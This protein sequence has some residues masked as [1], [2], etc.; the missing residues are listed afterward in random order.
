MVERERVWARDLIPLVEPFGD[1][2]AA[3]F[4]PLTPMHPDEQSTVALCLPLDDD[5][6]N[7]ARVCHA[8]RMSRLDRLFRQFEPTMPKGKGGNRR[9]Y[10]D[11]A[12]VAK[13]NAIM[14]SSGTESKAAAVREAAKRFPELF[15]GDGDDENKI[16]RITRQM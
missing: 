16:K 5:K 12:I 4:E 11:D 2:T 14:E 1:G 15:H 7:M 10:N 6:F 3:L 8:V 9:T 13:A